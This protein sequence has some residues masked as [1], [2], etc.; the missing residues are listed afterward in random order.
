MVEP[1]GG[2]SNQDILLC[3]LQLLTEVKLVWPLVP[4]PPRPAPQRHRRL[5]PDQQ[6]EPIERYLAGERAFGL[7][8]EFKVHRSTVGEFLKAAGVRCPRSLT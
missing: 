3:K 4:S 7:A 6:I 5:P 8:E 1:L 2:N